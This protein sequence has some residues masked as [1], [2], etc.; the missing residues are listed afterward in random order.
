MRFRTLESISGARRL[1]VS[2]LLATAIAQPGCSSD[3]GPSSPDARSPDPGMPDAGMDIPDGGMVMVD[4]APDDGM[5]GIDAGMLGEGAVTLAGS[6]MPG[7]SDGARDTASF[8]NP[9]NVVTGPDGNVYAA[10]FGNDSIRRITP[11]GVVT[12]LTAQAN[13]RRPFGMVFA[14]DGT[15]YVQTD[16]ND[17]G[18][19]SV[20][21]GTI[22]RLDLDSGEATVV[23]RNIGRPRGLAPLSD[24]RLVL[25]EGPRHSVLLLDPD[26]AA[27]APTLLA[28][29]NDPQGSGHV[30]A[31]G[32][33]ARFFRP[34][35]VVVVD[36]EIYLADRENHRIRK[37]TLDGVV[38]TLAGAGTPGSED[39]SMAQATFNRPYGVAHDNAGNVYV[40]E[41]DGYRIRKIDLGSGMVT[42]IAGTGTP[43]HLDAED[44]MEAQFFGLEG[45]D[46][47][48]D[49]YLYAADGSRG[50]DE[51]YHRIRRVSLP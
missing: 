51:P 7:D 2:L 19:L 40:S 33:E 23:V 39:G 11:A 48:G 13:F 26:A 17:A 30:D 41:V 31:T 20:D 45:I 18:G 5:P 16:A 29:A 43:G 3:D 15:L 34:Q 47:A 6:G 9:V 4:A 25:A 1:V 42:T 49:M 14:A 12:T 37:I 21:T 35:D 32:A 38:T 44:P 22:W 46:V 24:G 10:D 27:P 8:D 50:E 28:G 36:D